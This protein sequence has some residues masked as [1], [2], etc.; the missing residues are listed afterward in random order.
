MANEQNNGCDTCGIASTRVPSPRGGAN[1][2]PCGGCG[3]YGCGGRCGDN[4]GCSTGSCG[5]TRPTPPSPSNPRTPSPPPPAQNGKGG[6]VRVPAPPRTGKVD[7]GRSQQPP[8]PPSIRQGEPTPPPP[9]VRTK[10]PDDPIGNNGRVPDKSEG[11]VRV[12]APPKLD[13]GGGTVANPNS[14]GG[15]LD[16]ATGGGLL[17]RKVQPT[18][19]KGGTLDPALGGGAIVPGNTQPQRPQDDTQRRPGESL[20]DYCRRFPGNELCPQQPGPAPAPVV[21]STFCQN[22]LA[23]DFGGDLAKAARTTTGDAELC[24]AEF[25]AAYAAS[26]TRAAGAPAALWGSAIRVRPAGAPEVPAIASRAGEPFSAA[27]INAAVQTFLTLPPREQSGAMVYGFL[28]QQAAART[29]ASDTARGVADAPRQFLFWLHGNFAADSPEVQAFAA[30]L[31]A[32]ASRPAGDV[33]AQPLAPIFDYGTA[34]ELFKRLTPDAQIAVLRGVAFAPNSYG[35]VLANTLESGEL[36]IDGLPIGEVLDAWFQT[37][38]PPDAG[39]RVL[40]AYD[41]QRAAENTGLVARPAGDVSVESC[42]LQGWEA[43]G[44]RSVKAQLAALD[45]L[46]ASFGGPTS[47]WALARSRLLAWAPSPIG[48]QYLYDIVGRPSQWNPSEVAA[49]C[50]LAGAPTPTGKS[51]GG[52][53]RALGVT[54]PSPRGSTALAHPLALGMYRPSGVPSQ[55]DINA[56]INASFGGGASVSASTGGASATAGASPIPGFTAAQWAS[57]TSSN[58]EMA[59]RLLSEAN[60][61]PNTFQQVSAALLQAGQTAINAVNASE[62]ADL[63]R[64]RLQMEQERALAQARLAGDQV[65]A[66]NALALAQNNLAALNAQAAAAAAAM[67]TQLAQQ[68]PAQSSSWTPGEVAGA[69]LGGTVALG[70]VVLGVKSFL[71]RRDATGGARSRAA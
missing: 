57:L 45:A 46:A 36:T 62:T 32:H 1:R 68:Q 48:V 51:S 65:Q 4:G 25:D 29:F 22:V 49:F 27:E 34:I 56:A 66:Q 15:T 67:S 23:R 12:P 58:P 35:R 53:V 6:G 26:T 70:V 43:L 17:P 38:I 55:D 69:A 9:T 61:R 60:S 24:Q 30:A 52:S 54:V 31:V 41:T 3:G 64:Q 5:L 2:A 40:F 16:P 18:P 44:A 42:V 37:S 20:E 28:G 50:Q 71:D 21:L 13:N 8:P 10:T 39:E 14:Q 7:T 19:T 47:R 11:R 59:A 33:M 63:A